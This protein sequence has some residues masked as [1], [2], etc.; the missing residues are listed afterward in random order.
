MLLP[1]QLPLNAAQLGAK[2]PYVGR[3]VNRC[4]LV[5][6]TAKRG[7]RTRDINNLGHSLPFLHLPASL[8]VGQMSCSCM[9]HPVCRPNS[10]HGLQYACATSTAASL[11]PDAYT[12]T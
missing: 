1:L 6:C 4:C 5:L 10:M 3:H 8:D 9:H 2:L 11:T 7:R 12:M